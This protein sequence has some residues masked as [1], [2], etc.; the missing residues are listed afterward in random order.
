MELLKTQNR[1]NNPEENN[2]AGGIFQTL[3]QSYSNQN[4]MVLA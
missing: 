3:P 2:K 1:Q 4:S